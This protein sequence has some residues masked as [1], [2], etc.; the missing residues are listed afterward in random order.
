MIDG[1]TIVT[2]SIDHRPSFVQEP[3]PS[4]GGPA[5]ALRESF[6]S[7]LSFLPP[8]LRP[9]LLH[10]PLLQFWHCLGRA[11][12]WRSLGSIRASRIVLSRSSRLRSAAAVSPLLLASSARRRKDWRADSILCSPTSRARPSGLFGPVA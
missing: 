4:G 9:G 7:W 3:D 10:W 11:R 2:S 8:G 1:R 6:F 5:P 12:P